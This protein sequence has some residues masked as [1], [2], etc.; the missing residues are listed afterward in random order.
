MQGEK[1]SKK[2]AYFL[3]TQLSS[4]AEWGKGDY[5]TIT[6]QLKGFSSQDS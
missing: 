2:K 6:R 1:A 5:D 3:K 4:D